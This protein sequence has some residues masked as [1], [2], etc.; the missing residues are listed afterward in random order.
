MIELETGIER[1]HQAAL[2]KCIA[3]KWPRANRQTNKLNETTHF[4]QHN[5]RNSTAAKLVAK[6]S[7]WREIG[8]RGRGVGER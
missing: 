1:S 6:A 2:N 8:T 4:K 7:Q 5:A 3:A